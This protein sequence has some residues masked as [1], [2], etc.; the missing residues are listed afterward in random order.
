MEA[1]SL[2]TGPSLIPEPSSAL[3]DPPGWALELVRGAADLVWRPAEDGVQTRLLEG[4]RF[5]L[6][7]ARIPAALRLSSELFRAAT[8]AAYAAISRCLEGC[9]AFHPVRC[10]NLIPG[11]L[12][13]L[14]EHRHRYMVFNAGRHDAFAKWLGAGTGKRGRP[15]GG[16]SA[17]DTEAR[18]LQHLP[19]AS[20][21]GRAGEELVVHCL[22]ACSPGVPVE[23]PRQVPSYR[24]SERYGQTPPCFARATRLMDEPGTAGWVLVGGTASVRGEQTVHAGD[25]QAQTEETVA[26]LEA[27]LAAAAGSAGT[28]AAQPP[29]GFR[30]LRVYTP[31][32]DDLDRVRRLVGSCLGHLMTADGSVELLHAELCR[33]DLL[34]EIEGLAILE[35]A[36]PVSGEALRRP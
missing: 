7:S 10:W 22:A 25:L 20:G 18:L 19:T 17:G 30:H 8:A 2:S 3:G 24:Y 34:I 26:N 16:A 14:G 32:L 13:P 33:P 5:V 4:Q 27:L 1:T 29:S 21:V 35:A 36:P 11:I 9:R 15:G 28:G 6:A 12:E 23:N 31:R